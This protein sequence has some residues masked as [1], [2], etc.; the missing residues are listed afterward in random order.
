VAVQFAIL[1][2]VEVT[3]GGQRLAV[4]GQRARAVLARLIVAANSVVAAEAITAELW[5]DLETGRAAAVLQVRVA[6]LRRVLR[7][8]EAADRLVTRAPGYVLV[9]SPEE[10]DTARFDQLAGQGRALL[11]AGD[12]ASAAGC[13]ERALGLWR[14]PPLADVGDWPWAQAEAA[15]L[16]EA[17]LAAV[18]CH[19]QARLG[20]GDSSELI[21]ELEALIAGHRLR[22]RLWALR[23]LALYRCGRQAEALAAYQQLR[24]TLVEELGIEP[25]PDLRELH[26]QILAQDPGLSAAPP[27]APPGAAPGAGPAAETLAVKDDAPAALPALAAGSLPAAAASAPHQ[28][29]A[30]VGGFTGRAL[31]L[32]ELDFLLPTAGQQRGAAPGP[33]VISAVA[34][35]AGVG[36]TALAVRWAHRV[37]GQFPDGQLYVNLRGYDPGQPVTPGEALAGFLRALGVADADIPLAE[38]ERSA[39]YRSLVAGK[40]L[41]VVLDNAATVAQVRPLL[42]GTGTAMVVVTSRDSLAGLVAV[43]GA[44]RLDLDLLPPGEAVALL[45]ALI[46]ARADADPAAAERLVRLCAR[47]PLAL[48]VAAELAASRPKAP[49]A[50]LV[51]ELAGE[52]SRLEL[53]EA[54][55]DPHGAV[56]SVFSWSYRHLRADAGRMFRLLGLHPAQHWDPYAAAALTAAGSLAQAQRALRELARAHLIQAAGPGHYQM[57]DLLRAY[58][59]SLATSHDDNQACQAALA[60]LFYYYLA[61]STAAA[62]C[63]SPAYRTWRPDPPPVSTPVPEFSDLGAA[64]AWLDAELPTLVRVAEYTVGHGWPDYS[65]RLGTTLHEYLVGTGH[66]TEGILIAT[67]ALDAAHG[68]GDLAAQANALRRLATYHCQQ[69]RLPQGIDCARQA[70]AL[71]RDLGDRLVQARAHY[72]LAVAQLFQ[73]RYQHSARSLR[74]ALALYRELGDQ[75]G[76]SNTLSAMGLI[77]LWQGRYQQ[78]V[79]QLRRALSVA[80]KTGNQPGEAE[81][82][83]S[84]GE[85]YWQL[86]DYQQATGYTQQALT[87]SREIGDRYCEADALLTLGRVRHRLGRYDQALSYQ[88]QAL[89]LYQEFGVRLFQAAAL[90]DTGETLLATGQ[91]TQ[92]QDSFTAALTVARQVSN[93]REQARALNGLGQVCYGQ[94]RHDQAAAYHQQALAL[95]QHIGDRGGRTEALNGT[96]ETLLATAE[97]TQAHDRFTAALTLASQTGDRYQQARAHHGLAAVCHAAGDNTSADQH[98]QHARDI[99]TSLGVPEATRISTSPGASEDPAVS[100][101]TSPTTPGRLV[102]Q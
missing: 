65:S 47:L 2:P 8:V 59:A 6:E 37:A 76:E 60:R 93:Q 91:H 46:G 70:V 38:A 79:S 12:A 21:A 11:A 64:Q 80:R 94:G 49:L 13:L 81:A 54:G 68:T 95:Y 96:A 102:S 15:R 92:A 72:Q 84:L 25:A 69:G 1:G 52:P 99:Y 42:P 74:H 97:H 33:V 56:A 27:T 14:G 87:I 30:E 53:L 16:G 48:R 41:L 9:A 83:D 71:A 17:R 24:T 75:T 86:G 32:A 43:D 63:L 55:G 85:A 20:C 89:A 58:A 88:H 18:E 45:G 5:P 26:Q 31:E 77:C 78:A 82:L 35:T 51:A 22:E 40:R 28:L 39:R 66:Y 67:C 36:K 62:N 3:A 57:H 7:R 90:T 23:M 50:E 73:G 29:P 34:G 101:A 44:R 61:A 4:G 98:W 19:L 100:P 10:V